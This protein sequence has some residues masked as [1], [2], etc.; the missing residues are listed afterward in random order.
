M[1]QR[2]TIL[3][4]GQ[5]KSSEGEFIWELENSYEL[6]PKLSEQILLTAKESLFRGYQ[7]KEG[8]IE[9]TVISIEQRA[10]KTIEKLEKKRV[11]ITIDNGIE[12]NELLQA[13]GRIGLRQT[14]IQRITQEAIEQGGVLSQEDISKYLSV[15]IRT[16]K[17]DISEIKKR[18]IGVITRGQLHN[19]GRGQ[20]HKVKIIGMYLD[21]KM[22]SEIRLS[23]RH[24]IGAI[25]RYIES[26][27]KVVM[28]RSKG[29]YIA[30]EISLV[31][32]ISECL[33]KQYNELIKQSKKDKIRKEN[34]KDLIERNSYRERI[35]KTVV[36]YKEPLAAMM[37]GIQ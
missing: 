31:T 22:Y 2:R 18:G 5:I 11:R 6:S 7:L 30:K 26:F 13:Y 25:K 20:T 35:K 16:I 9:V 1:K 19:I 34:L 4:R 28:A 32:G 27:T 3:N 23:T 33:V 21:G 29:I 8:Q 14:K 17:R 24:S 12:D 37:G 15:S 10:G 36:S